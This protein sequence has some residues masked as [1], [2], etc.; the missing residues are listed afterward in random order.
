MAEEN[1]FAQNLAR[2]SHEAG[3]RGRWSLGVSTTCLPPL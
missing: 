2:I 1:A 3:R